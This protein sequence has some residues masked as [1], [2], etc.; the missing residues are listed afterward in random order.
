MDIIAGCLELCGNWLIGN[1][2]KWG[3]VLNFVGCVLWICVAIHFKIYGLL[4]VVI[5]ALFINVRNFI[6]WI[7]K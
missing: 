6:K 5:P 4:I 3:F 7:K 2:N 1:K